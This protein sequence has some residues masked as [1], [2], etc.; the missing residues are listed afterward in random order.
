ML[1]ETLPMQMRRGYVSPDAMIFFKCAERAGE[2]MLD[3]VTKLKYHM[4][5]MN[6]DQDI[7]DWFGPPNFNGFMQFNIPHAIRIQNDDSGLTFVDMSG[8]NFDATKVLLLAAT[9]INRETLPGDNKQTRVAFG[10]AGFG[11]VLTNSMQANMHINFTAASLSDGSDSETLS[12]NSNNLPGGGMNLPPDTLGVVYVLW[13]G[14]NQ[15]LT[16]KFLNID[17]S[18]YNDGSQDFIL[19]ETTG[20]TN[21]QVEVI[22]RNTSRLT[23]A[24]YYSV[25]AAKYDVV[26]NLLDQKLSQWGAESVKGHK[27]WPDL[28]N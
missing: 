16:G 2:Q 26:P 28:I 27:G 21:G 18:I 12:I 19:N 17:G 13:D 24:E 15:V 4:K 10:T 14:P 9:T 22:M 20:L 8:F 25:V 5:I 11:N 3:S 1:I 23:N 6:L 7:I